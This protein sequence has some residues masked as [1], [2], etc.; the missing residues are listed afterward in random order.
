MHLLVYLVSLKPCKRAAVVPLDMT[1]E[2]IGC[3]LT[4]ALGRLVV[5]NTAATLM[6]QQARQLGVTPSCAKAV[7]NLQTLDLYSD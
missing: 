7:C 3:L 6:K 4:C 5:A 2:L 1:V